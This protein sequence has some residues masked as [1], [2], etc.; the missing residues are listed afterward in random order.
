MVKILEA[1]SYQVQGH[2][3]EDKK[4]VETGTL[5]ENFILLNFIEVSFVS[6]QGNVISWTQY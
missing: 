3:L 1:S 2:Q 4:N 5:N 6:D